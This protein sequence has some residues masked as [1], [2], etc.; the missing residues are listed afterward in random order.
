[1]ETDT[2]MDTEKYMDMIWT[3]KSGIILLP[4]EYNIVDFDISPISFI[5]DIGLSYRGINGKN[6]FEVPLMLL[7]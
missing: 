5:T 6:I 7:C 2:D 4:V 3:L 1:M